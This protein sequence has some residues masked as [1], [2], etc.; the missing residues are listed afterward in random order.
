MVKGKGKGKGKAKGKN[1]TPTVIEGISTEEM[2]KE[3]LEEHIVNIREELDREREERNYFQLERDK[4]NT[5]WEITKRQLDEKK[6]ELRNKDREM[7]DSEER[8]QVEIKVMKQ[9]VKHLLYEHQ[10]N[11]AQLK[12][13]AQLELKINNEMNDDSQSGL[14]GDK[15]HLKISMKE[16]ELSHEDVIRNLKKSHDSFITNLREEFQNQAKEIEDKYEKKLKQLR[17]ELDI[18]RKTEIHEIEERK[19][20]QINTL[21]RNH[22]KAFS[23]IKN[24]YNDITLNNLSLINTLKTEIEDIKKQR[25][26][27][28]KQMA[29]ILA[30]NKKLVE[31]LQKANEQVSDLQRQLLSYDKDKALLASTKG[32]LK[33]TEENYS[34]LEWEHEVFNQRYD[35]TV[36]ERDDLYKKFVKAIHD[37]QQKSNL[38]NLLLEK[39]L[40]ALGDTL[41]KK[42]AQLNEVLTASNLDPSALSVV[43]RKLEDVLDSKN[44]A[45]KDLQY[46]LARVCKAHNDLLRTYEAKLAQYGIPVEEMGFKPLESSIGG[47][48]QQLGKGAS[49]LVSAPT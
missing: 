40:G 33:E 13:E 45:I 3:Q 46:E 7:E 14:R 29:E 9:K 26:R 6:A 36:K 34:K 25:E 11:L 43:T 4:I 41:E 48:Q 10:N 23:D 49:G 27:L 2:T 16:Q 35:N 31:P 44:G 28:E 39:K 20:Q 12:S 30:E 37:V 19:N 38:K 42:E 22:E 1:K 5:F 17:D 32:R 18:R 47:T 24:Y 21:M 15:R 8:H